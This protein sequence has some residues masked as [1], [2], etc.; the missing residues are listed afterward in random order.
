ML[1]T[2]FL[3]AKNYT[4]NYWTAAF[5]LPVQI[6]GYITIFF[7]PWTQLNVLQIILYF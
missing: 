4:V 6:L 5:V 2:E 3:D 7:Y 1:A